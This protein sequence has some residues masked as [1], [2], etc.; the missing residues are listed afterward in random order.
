MKTAGCLGGLSQQR[1]S[2]CRYF[3]PDL[4]FRGPTTLSDEIA[5]GILQS[6]G[7]KPEVPTGEAEAGVHLFANTLQLM[8]V[9]SISGPLRFEC[10]GRGLMEFV[11]ESGCGVGRNAT[12]YSVSPFSEFV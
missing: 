9:W 3:G 6:S 2:G 11:A 8:C 4:F 10:Q 7:Q 12:T 1:S 5:E